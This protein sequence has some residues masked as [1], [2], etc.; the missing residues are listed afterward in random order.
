MRVK[1]AL[2]EGAPATGF[3]TLNGTAE[4][5]YNGNPA[6][7]TFTVVDRGDS[8]LHKD[9][10]RITITDASGVVLTISNWYI[11]LGSHSALPV[12]AG[13]STRTP[14]D[15]P[16]GSGPPLRC[17]ALRPRHRRSRAPSATPMP[18]LASAKRAIERTG[19]LRA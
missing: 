18:T 14:R 12:P 19:G 9:R 2:S 13:Q 15:V 11:G 6:T 10:T 4:G 5:T 17:S 1:S 3:N 16:R 8:N 7:A